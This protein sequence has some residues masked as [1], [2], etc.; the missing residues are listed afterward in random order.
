MPF[1]DTL[2]PELII[3]A[4][5]GGFFPM[6]DPDTGEILWYNPDPRAIL[7]LEGFHIS[8]SLRRTSKKKLLRVT[9]DQGFADVVEGCANRA[10]TWISP[11]IKQS[12]VQLF[13]LGYAHS[14]E[15]WS[16]QDGRL[17]GGLYGV[18]QGGVFNA[19]SMF[20]RVKDASKLA[21]W[22][23]VNRMI[24]CRMTLLEVQFLTPHLQSLG[25]VN[26]KKDKYIQDLSESLEAPGRFLA[27]LG[28]YRM[29]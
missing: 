29:P 13:E 12:Y 11:L 5:R 3:A 25:A 27:P 4:Y 6:P 24:E 15:V 23:L 20:S 9:F 18:A 26:V 19:E 17:V 1:E 22:A 21:L 7:P 10:S 14:V 2:S 28:D 8:K 16:Q